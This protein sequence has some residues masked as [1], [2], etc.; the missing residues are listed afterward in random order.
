M[1]VKTLQYFKELFK[2]GYKITE[3]DYADWLDSFRHVGV[4][5]N[6]ADTTGLTAILAGYMRKVD[7]LPVA[8]VTGLSDLINNMLANYLTMSSQIPQSQIVGLGSTLAEFVTVAVVSQMITDGLQSVTPTIGG[9]GNW[10]VGGVDTGVKAGGSAGATPIIGDTG[11][12]VIDGVD[13]GI[14]ALPKSNAFIT[15]YNGDILG[16]RGVAGAEL[17]VGDNYVSG[18]LAVW[19]DGQML[20]KGGGADFFERGGNS[21]SL[22]RLTDINSTKLIVQYLKA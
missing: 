21:F 17:S 1:A 10:H 18:S 5:V 9:N 8:Q 4:P 14:S 7:N 12:W 22:N 3:A 20:Q 13:T 15:K 19:M 2:T 11:N 6:L 16:P